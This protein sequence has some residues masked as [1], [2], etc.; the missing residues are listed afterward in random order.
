M[1]EL[2]RQLYKAKKRV[3]EMTSAMLEFRNEILQKIASLIQAQ[4][5]GVERPHITEIIYKNI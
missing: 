5:L 4:S 3:E 2:V 1:K